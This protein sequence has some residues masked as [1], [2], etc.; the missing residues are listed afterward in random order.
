MLTQLLLDIE[1]VEGESESL[2]VEYTADGKA[3]K[4]VLLLPFCILQLTARWN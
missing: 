4:L 1:L 3:K 2:S